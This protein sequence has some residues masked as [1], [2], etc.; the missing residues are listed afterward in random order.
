MKR[1]KLY[2]GEIRTYSFR[3]MT[4]HG[5][6]LLI[7]SNS[8]TYK[9]FSRLPSIQTS[10]KLCVNYFQAAATMVTFNR[11]LQSS[12]TPFQGFLKIDEHV[13]KMMELGLIDASEAATVKRIFNQMEN[14]LRGDFKLH[15]K[16]QSR[17]ADH[18]L[19]WALS[20]PDDHRFASPPP[21]PHHHDWTCPDCDKMDYIVKYE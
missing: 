18:C 1:K 19:N 10:S 6:E 12:H 7:L 13:K 8:T 20:D 5:R 14:Y 17:I 21:T 16:D 9:M 4:Q 2:L 11:Y 3:W 15:V